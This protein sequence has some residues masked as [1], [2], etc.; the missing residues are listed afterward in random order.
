MK[1]SK[2]LVAVALLL[3]VGSTVPTAVAGEEEKSPVYLVVHYDEVEP[4]M[5]DE[6]EANGKAW[7]E[8]FT[9]KEMGEEWTW[10]AYSRPGF[11]YAY[12][13]TMPDYA[14][15][16]AQPERE[17]M[18]AEAL[19]EEKMKELMGDMGAI[20]SHHSEILKA[21]PELS[22]HPEESIVEQGNFVQVDVHNVKPAM[23]EQFKDAVKRAVAAFEKAGAKLGFDA[24]EIEFGQGSYSFVTF[25]E[26]AAQFYS[27]PN[28]GAILAEA[29]GPEFAEKLFAEWRDCIDGFETSDWRY[30]PDMSYVPG[31]TSAEAE[32]AEAM[33]ESK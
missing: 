4:S 16:D 11:T 6:Y 26:S 13:F 18:M 24:Y 7:V 25:A 8:A 27:Q 12:V 3:V 14:Y 17:K 19:G 21:S 29:E 1:G 5:S 22:Y 28:A 23:N 30:R 20:R 9:E 33:E 32:E 10:W 31:M 15:L 2:S